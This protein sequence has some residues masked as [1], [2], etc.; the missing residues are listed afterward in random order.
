MHKDF[1]IFYFLSFSLCGSVFYYVSRNELFALE[2]D[3]QGFVTTDSNGRKTFTKG[4]VMRWELE[5]GT[6]SLKLADV[7]FY[8]RGEMGQ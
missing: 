7:K 6:F 3:V 5:I 8:E 2:I 4:S 1:A